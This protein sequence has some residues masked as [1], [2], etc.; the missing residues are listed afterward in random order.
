MRIKAVVSNTLFIAFSLILVLGLIAILSAQTRP[1]GQSAAAPQQQP[2]LQILTPPPRPTFNPTEIAEENMPAVAPVVTPVPPEMAI[3]AGV[4]NLRPFVAQEHRLF[5]GWSPDGTL[6]LVRKKIQNHDY[7]VHQYKQGFGSH[8]TLG[9]LWVVDANGK[10]VMKISDAVGTWAWSPDSKALL[11]TEP[12][13]PKGG[14]DGYL[15]VVHLDSGEV[16]RIAQTDDFRT[17]DENLSGI[18]WLPTG[19][20]FFSRGGSLYRINPDG[21]DLSVV[22]P[23]HIVSTHEEDEQGNP[24]PGTAYSVCSDESKIAYTL[25][26]KDNPMIPDLW[27]ANLDGSEAVRVIDSTPDFEWNP[28]C[29]QLALS[30]GHTY[31]GTRYDMNIMVVDRTGKNLKDIVPVSQPDEINDHPRWAST[32]DWIIYSKRVPVYD[33]NGRLE[34]QLWKVDPN[35]GKAAQ[36]MQHAGWISYLSPDGR[37]LAFNAQIGSVIDGTPDTMN[38]FIVQVDLSK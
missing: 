2:T 8:A 20:I 21:I 34:I 23:L 32:G 6:S 17:S 13:D 24:I 14:S 11:Y 12:V 5:L 26:S 7:V 29:T 4:S 25:V 28:D 27:I 15:L 16:S 30:H 37:W 1:G 38:A 19:H 35:G 31:P 9:D 36:L 18:Q 22:T 33:P 10:D 3:G